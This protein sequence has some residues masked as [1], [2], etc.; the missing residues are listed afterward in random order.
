[1]A[2][3][4]GARASSRK[5]RMENRGV[6]QTSGWGRSPTMSRHGT[7]HALAR[8]GHRPALPALTAETATSA[9]HQPALPAPQPR[10]GGGMGSFGIGLLG[11]NGEAPSDR[12]LGASV[13]RS[14]SLATREFGSGTWTRTRDHS[15][16]SRTLYQ[17]S[18]PGKGAK[19]TETAADVKGGSRGRP[20]R[21]SGRLRRRRGC[22][23][24]GSRW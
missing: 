11:R 8:P 20:S 4:Y 12:S 7:E 14:P 21:R 6:H 15:V 19:S 22:R 17:L 13:R 5:I 10:R 18:Y 24:A 2:I 9:R 16:N 1:M 23:S 3:S